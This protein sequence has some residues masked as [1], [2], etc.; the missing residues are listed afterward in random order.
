MLSES[1]LDQG[2]TSEVFGDN[3]CV[4]THCPSNEDI[5]DIFECNHAG[6]TFK[7][8]VP[9]KISCTPQVFWAGARI[10]QKEAPTIILL[11]KTAHG[12]EP[13]TA[14]DNEEEGSPLRDGANPD[15]M[16]ASGE[17]REISGS[18]P[19]VSSPDHL[20]LRK[21]LCDNAAPAMAWTKPQRLASKRIE[22]RE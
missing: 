4:H 19:G 2:E 7:A 6:N 14:R 13:F 16:L 22:S 20:S 17:N 1:Y 9:P 10:Q 11:G 12:P 3:I 8:P 18:P 15:A 21:R 5:N